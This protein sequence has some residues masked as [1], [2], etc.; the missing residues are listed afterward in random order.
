[1]INSRELLFKAKCI[2]SIDTAANCRNHQVLR[3]SPWPWKLKEYEFLN[4]KPYT[5][6][7]LYLVQQD[8]NM[9]LCN[10]ALYFSNLNYTYRKK[11]I[12]WWVNNTIQMFKIAIIY[13]SRGKKRRKK[14]DEYP[15]IKNLSIYILNMF[16]LNAQSIDCTTICSKSV[17]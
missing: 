5:K 15:T 3:V 12:A 8:R 7:N 14:K 10:K 17:E 11:W 4:L 1:M 13:F 9:L 16:F 6:T 2:V